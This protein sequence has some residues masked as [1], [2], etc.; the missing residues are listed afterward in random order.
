VDVVRQ[1]RASASWWNQCSLSHLRKAVRPR[2][3]TITF[4]F[5]GRGSNSTI[6]AL[7]CQL[8]ILAA[9]LIGIVMSRRKSEIALRAS[10]D[11][12]SKHTEITS[13]VPMK[14]F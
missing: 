1:R 13:D 8:V 7:V 12:L 6:F 9:E 10:S 5:V 2:I 11:F 4:V 14:R 3:R